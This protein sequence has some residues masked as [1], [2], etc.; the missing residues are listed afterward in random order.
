MSSDTSQHQF[1]GSFDSS[2][3]Q[4]L[5]TIQSWLSHAINN[6]IF[7]PFSSSPSRGTFQDGIFT[8]GANGRITVDLLTGTGFT[9]AELALFSLKD[10]KSLKGLDWIRKAYQ[11]ALSSSALGRIVLSG[12]RQGPKYDFVSGIDAMQQPWQLVCFEHKA[13]LIFT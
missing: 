3:A 9:Q 5:S 10:L 13:Y 12:H 8:V 6:Q 2:I 1:L 11:R 7:S 4:T